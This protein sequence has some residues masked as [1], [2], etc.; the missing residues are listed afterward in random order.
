L[1]T[2][3]QIVTGIGGIIMTMAE[4]DLK[5]SVALVTGGSRGIGRAICIAL[6]RAGAHVAV[7]YHAH[8]EQ[9][10]E[11]LQ[12]IRDCGSEA[13]KIQADVA[14]QQA[15]DRMT[16]Q[17]VDRFGKLDIAIAN[18]AYSEREPFVE[19]DMVKF[20]RTVDVTMWGALYVTRAAARAMIQMGNA[21][22]IVL[23][24]S[25][26]AFLAIPGSMAYNLSKA[27]VE[28]FAKTAALELA[29]HRI[30][31]NI[32][33]PGWID[34]PGERKFTSEEALKRAGR[35]IPLGRLGRAEE[36]ADA[37]LFLCD[38]RHEYMTGTALLVDGGISLPWWG[39]HAGPSK[40][41]D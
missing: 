3:D 9:A 19:A 31:V 39:S 13:I 17:V 6:A 38:A 12:A 27:A 35:R 7:N 16:S 10:E 22:R 26:H 36:I 28:M 18:A 30:R 33:Q 4:N 24:S 32:I 23:V 14:D 29:P 2:G 25:P 40:L 37:V 41:D 15:V 20:R 5:G 11:V 34:T 21:G 8:H 1:G